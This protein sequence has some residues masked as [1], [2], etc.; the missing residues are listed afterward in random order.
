MG[1][2]KNRK[3]VAVLRLMMRGV[4]GYSTAGVE[5]LRT[6]VESLGMIEVRMS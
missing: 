1:G 6:A 4:A 3:V 5:G 2:T